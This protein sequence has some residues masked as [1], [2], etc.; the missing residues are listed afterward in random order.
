[1]PEGHQ[2]RTARAM[3]FAS[4]WFSA[5]G[6][7]LGACFPAPP[8]VRTALLEF[9]HPFTSVNTPWQSSQ[10]FGRVQSQYCSAYR[11]PLQWVYLANVFFFLALY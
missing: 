3:G 8:L 10:L 2:S 9:I 7:E 5:E 1:M 4:A 6:G 11:G